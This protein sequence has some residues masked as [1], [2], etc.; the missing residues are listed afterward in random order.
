MATCTKCKGSGY[1]ATKNGG[2]KKCP[3]CNNGET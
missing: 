1:L 3:F 2:V